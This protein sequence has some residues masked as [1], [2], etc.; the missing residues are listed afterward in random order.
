MP[1]RGFESLPFHATWRERVHSSRGD[2]QDR[3]HHSKTPSAL[4][5]PRDSSSA[6]STSLRT[7]GNSPPTKLLDQE[8]AYV[9]KRR[10]LTCETSKA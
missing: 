5:L 3:A 7:I 8:A 9:N 4:H 2:E 6:V 1:G 10:R